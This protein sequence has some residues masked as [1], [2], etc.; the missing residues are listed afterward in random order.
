ISIQF[1]QE[2]NRRLM[3]N[4]GSIINTALGST[5]TSNGDIRKF[6]VLSGSGGYYLNH[7]KVPDALRKLVSEGNKL[8]TEA[9]TPIEIHNLAFDFH[10]NLVTIHPF[11]DGNGRVSRLM[12]NYI[13]WFHNEPITIINSKMKNEYIL[14]IVKTRESGDFTYIRSFLKEQHCDYLSK[15]MDAFKTIQGKPTDK[16]NRNNDF[17]MSMV[18]V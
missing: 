14:A 3:K 12:M 4:S 11:G 18:F 13:Q 10:Y 6:A 5:D 7:E 8:L 2:L 9:K 15:E 17:G 16:Q 1:I